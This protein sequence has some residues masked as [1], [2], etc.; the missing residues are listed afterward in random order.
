MRENSWK[1]IEAPKRYAA[2]QEAFDTRWFERF[3]EVGNFQAHEYFEGDKAVRA[4]EKET[5]LSGEVENPQLDYPKLDR[6]VIA[7]REQVLLGLKSEIIADEE[8]SV[9][10]QVYRWRINE[11]LAE[12]RLMRAAI[13]GDMKRFKRYTEFIYGA[14]SE[15]LAQYTINE[16]HELLEKGL[17]SENQRAKELSQELGLLLPPQKNT[18]INRPGE[19]AQRVVTE[20]TQEEFS[21]LVVISEKEKG[22][23]FSTEEIQREFERALR[24][25]AADGW[26]AMI[27]RGSSAAVNTSQEEREVK[28]PEA[29]E[30]KLGKTLK[31]LLVHEVGTHV[32]R[33]VNGERTRLKLLSLGLDRYEGGEEGVARMREEAVKGK[34]EE[35]AGINYYLAGTLASGT[36]DQPRDFR[37]TFEIIVRYFELQN[38][39]KGKST[40]E[41]SRNKAQTSAW[42]TCVRMF[43]GTDTKTPGVFFTKDLIYREGNIAVWDTVTKNIPGTNTPEMMRWSV[44]KYDPSNDRHIWILNELGITDT[45]LARLEE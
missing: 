33:R 43:R 27:N 23:K 12:L 17:N 9:V 8:N 2:K 29:K 41:E 6:E 19:G 31:G 20:N 7:S 37:K 28:I 13:D 3:A 25:I 21:S 34:L 22:E 44:G 11:K 16:A 42:N 18:F 26:I 30:I 40:S 14:P 35:F 39:L 24:E 5:F 45:D 4:A 1:N 38:I 36:L 32:K 15:E 10:R